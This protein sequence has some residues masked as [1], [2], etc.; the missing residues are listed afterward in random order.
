MQYIS[1]AA[2]IV[3][4]IVDNDRPSLQKVKLNFIFMLSV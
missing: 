4:K 2:L 3:L 1:S